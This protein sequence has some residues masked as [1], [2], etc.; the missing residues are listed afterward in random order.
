MEQDQ[1]IVLRV[2]D[3]SEHSQI[4]TLFTRA[5]GQVRLIA[6]GARRGTKQRVAPGLDLLELGQL[7]FARPRGDAGL[8]TLVEW[9]QMDA[10][11]GLRDRPAPLHAGLYVAEL[12]AALTVEFDPE[13][14]LF[15]AALDVLRGLSAG[16][17]G[18]PSIATW[19]RPQRPEEAVPSGAL[20]VAPGGARS[21]A[22]RG[23]EPIML[24]VRF[25]AA[26]LRAIGYSPNLRSCAHCGRP[27][28]A[29]TPA[30]FSSSGG[31]FVCARCV[32][33]SREQRRIPR[34]ILASGRAAPA[35]LW[36]ELLDYHLSQLAGRP[37]HAARGV[38]TSRADR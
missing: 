17:S 35:R 16:Q 38:L 5:A 34:A 33:K 25:Q 29:S 20:P 24:A 14:G 2:S 3:Y 26:L 32:A 28:A 12:L 27:P 10:F 13:P 15:D 37:L 11:L 18:A 30:F 19:D 9:R 36:F 31:G 7:S 21:T 8:G 22:K 4:I 23:D 6:K 1:G